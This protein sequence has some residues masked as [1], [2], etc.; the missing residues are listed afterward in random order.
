[1]T[2]TSNGSKAIATKDARPKR[3]ASFTS[4]QARK[5][6]KSAQH[7]EILTDKN[8]PGFQLYMNKEKP[9]W[10]Y[11]YSDPITGKRHIVVIGPF[12]WGDNAPGLTLPAA[13]AIYDDWVSSERGP[14]HE[15]AAKKA[16]IIESEVAAQ[17]EK[18]AGKQRT[19]GAYLAH[20]YSARLRGKRGEGY[21][22]IERIKSVFHGL[23]D[24]DMLTLSAMDIYEWQDKREANGR[25]RATLIRD[26]GGLKKA[27]KSAFEDGFIS[28]DPLAG[29]KLKVPTFEQ[30]KAIHAESQKDD[31]RPFTDD[32]L[33][34]LLKGLAAFDA[35]TREGRR[36]SRKHGKAYLPDLDGV[37]FA[38]W[39]IPFT[40]LA[41]HTGLR[42]GDLFSLQWGS[43][44]NLTFGNLTKVPE[45]TLHNANPARIVMPLNSVIRKIM[46]DW[47]EQSGKPESGLVFPSERNDGKQLSKTAHNKPW[48]SVKRL[49]GLPDGLV[50]YALRH[51]FASKLIVQQVPI[52]T[53]A[54]LLGHKTSQMVEH[55]YAHLIP[56]HAKGVLEAFAADF[57]E[58]ERG[59]REYAA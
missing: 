38:H 27:V 3:K 36:N 51:H 44:L 21:A 50:F 24:R 29:V 45:K 43:E 17:R 35:E 16:A 2:T 57:V 46:R 34:A 1:M 39:F 31:R 58:L 5:F 28:S 22:T 42:V 54:T 30:Q 18:E 59:G 41:L 8:N 15:R 56:D 13:L 14:K 23:L 19:L 4:D 55:T 9:V 10:R 33:R 52:K 11:R 47:W 48:I 12:A 20:G 7:A 37:A 26:Y 32:E 53:V 6:A 40:H 49:G 25:A